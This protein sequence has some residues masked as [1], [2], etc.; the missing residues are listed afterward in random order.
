[1]GQQEDDAARLKRAQQ[2]AAQ[3][4]AKLVLAVSQE[5][6]VGDALAQNAS[7]CR[8]E[9][10]ARLPPLAERV[11]R[12]KALAKEEHFR[13]E[14]AFR[15]LDDS[16][17]GILSDKQLSLAFAHI[18]A[19]LGPGDLEA[20]RTLVPARKDGKVQYS[21]YLLVGKKAFADDR[22]TANAIERRAAALCD[23]LARFDDND[24]GWLSPKRF[25]EAL[26]ANSDSIKMY[27]DQG[28]VDRCV[29]EA[30]PSTRADGA[31]NYQEWTGVLA[32]AKGM[33]WLL[34]VRTSRSVVPMIAAGKVDFDLNSQ[35]TLHRL[36]AF[37]APD[38][39][40]VGTLGPGM[41]PL[42]L[43]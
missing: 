35:R 40:A 7:A 29:R 10:A 25:R 3:R 20:L 17:T 15:D 31:V 30:R 18:G 12:L 33:P 1:M 26:G 39:K 42:G 9:L 23:H 28:E 27:L 36:A 13:L 22:R 41:N 37:T 4:H 38:G 19:P 43:K 16:Y 6:A 11:H 5:L 8:R 34:Q 24:S 21:Q 32:R 2:Q 14:R